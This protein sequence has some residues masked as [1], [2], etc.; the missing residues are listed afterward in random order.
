MPVLPPAGRTPATPAGEGGVSRR[1]HAVLATVLCA[2]IWGTL[3]PVAAQFAS[4]HTFH[5]AA[6]RLLIG[7]AVLHAASRMRGLPSTTWE[8]REVAA[9]LVSGVTIAGFS[10]AYFYAV[11]LSGVAASTVITVGGAPVLSGI[12][13]RF[14]HRESINR[15]W[16]VSTVVAVAGITLV[17]PGASARFSLPG[18]MLALL[19][20]ALYS[21]QAGALQIVARRHGPVTATATSFALGA[22]L[23]CP[24]LPGA[25]AW[26]AG[27]PR[28]L[29]SVM[30]IGVITTAGGYALFTYGVH[31]LG[32][33]TAV[34]FSLLEPAAAAALAAVWLDQGLS[35][36]RWAGL[37]VVL[38]GL[39]IMMRPDRP[40]S[41]PP[42]TAV[43]SAGVN[44]AE[45][46][47]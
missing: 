2:V 4:H 23:L 15:T 19:A 8:R 7:A 44:S 1:A 14:L 10:V 29:I 9:A 46:I 17:V 33:P 34:T 36:V 28:P 18:T 45:Q 22:V 38:C 32:A 47:V 41:S 11:E 31:H 39:A 26:A 25:V 13:A 43:D 5:I 40:A 3:G 30:Y 20:A 37:A 21:G 24:W 42:V 16:A 6:L 27:D 35:L 12:A